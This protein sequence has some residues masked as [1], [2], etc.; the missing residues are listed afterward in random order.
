MKQF[1]KKSLA[2]LLALL[3]VLTMAPLA[4]FAGDGD[5]T[6]PADQT[7]T[8]TP[9][10]TEPHL[11]HSF[12]T[13]P[14]PA[15]DIPAKQP[16]C[17]E[18]GHGRGWTCSVCGYVMYEDG[19]YK[20]KGHDW[21]L[22]E[23][24]TA[25]CG[26]EGKKI[27]E[28]S[29]CHATEERDKVAALEHVWG[30]W[31]TVKEPNSCTETGEKQRH[32]TRP[33]CNGVEYEVIPAANHKPQEVK[34][35]KATCT[36]AGNK[37]GT[38]CAVCGEVLSGCETVAP[39]GHDYQEK[40][41]KPTCTE[42]GKTTHTCSR[43]K[44]SYEDNLT[45]ALGHDYK[46]KT[47]DP[48]CTEKGKETGTCQRCGDKYTKEI[49]PLGHDWEIVEAVAPT[50]TEP[51]NT[52][53]KKC[54]TCGK[55][56]SVSK[57]L[58]AKGHTFTTEIVTPVT[59]EANGLTKKYCIECNYSE[60]LVEPATGHKWGDWIYSDSF[61]C[62][63]GGERYRIC[64]NCGEK[65]GPE[66]V[67]PQGH[68]WSKEWTVDTPATCTTKG[69]KSHHCTRCDAKNDITTVAKLPHSYIDKV[70]KATTKKDGLITGVCSVC[71]AERKPITLKRVKT[72]KLSKTSY[73]YDGKAKKPSVVVKGADGKKLKKDTDYKVTYASG[74]KKVGTYTVK[75]KL[76]GNYSGS[77]KLK[78]TIALGTP[79]G[80]EAETNK[81]KKTIT[82]SWAAVKG[83]SKYVVYYATEKN[84]EYEKLATVK[85][86]VY[87]VKT[88]KPGT[89]Y[90]KVCAMAKNNKDKT[91]YSE[92]SSPLKV[93][94]AK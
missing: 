5:T 31:K 87:T 50:C 19:N 66:P 61:K 53:G 62:D 58:P 71:G 69:Y 7:G 92:Y 67:K 2:A 36:T 60:T 70:T 15:P 10:A 35:V 75:V 93:K 91:V 39:L 4:V 72:I 84:G 41:I 37:A 74:R 28:C 85:K 24:I 46:I 14:M 34:E 64:D 83:A 25:A 23:T 13:D 89:Y 20:A 11:K 38:K 12:E 32:C 82:L 30:E 1:W 45:E 18:D 48:T 22:K 6:P 78:F 29:R 33:G 86:A 79:K 51:G 56:E 88:L 77:K 54:K 16:T 55:V 73:T 57:E 65:D 44:D 3:M 40:V 68:S 21:Q 49:D 90:F 80:L 42:G 9:P 63:V 59:C 47:T 76:I 8:E 43:C 81:A 27:Y 52:E 17:T 26:V 94:L